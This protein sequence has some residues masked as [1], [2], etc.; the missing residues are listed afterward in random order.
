MWATLT[1]V[2]RQRLEQITLQLHGPMAF[3]QPKI[4]A[5]LGLSD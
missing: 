4:V 5:R 2:Q 3:D 1:P